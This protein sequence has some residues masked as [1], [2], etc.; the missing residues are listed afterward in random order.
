MGL[1]ALQCMLVHVGQWFRLGTI[2]ALHPVNALV[3]AAVTREAIG[4]AAART[5]TLSGRFGRVVP[6]SPTVR[7][8]LA[9]TST[10]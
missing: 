8:I 9:D 4:Q 5:G 10:P 1:L 2:A 6:G 3:L 7:P